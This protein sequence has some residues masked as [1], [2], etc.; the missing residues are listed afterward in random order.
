MNGLVFAVAVNLLVLVGSEDIDFD[1]ILNL[2]KPKRR[3]N[4]DS[5]AD[6]I[7]TI[8]VVPGFYWQK[9][10][11]L[12][13]SLFKNPAPW[14]DF[15]YKNATKE[16]TSYPTKIQA[17]ASK[18]RIITSKDRIITSKDRV[19]TSKDRISTSKDDYLTQKILKAVEN[20]NR[21]KESQK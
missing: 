2:I 5:V 9:P 13:S 8:P 4:T 21:Y 18:D 7:E 20:L 11:D 3:S 16:D 17:S 19:S 15:R 14:P 6:S 10:K 12:S 1:T